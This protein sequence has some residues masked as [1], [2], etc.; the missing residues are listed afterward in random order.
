MD[1]DSAPNVKNKLPLTFVVGKYFF[2]NLSFEFIFSLTFFDYPLASKK[3]TCKTKNTN[4]D[5]VFFLITGKIY[6]Y[7]GVCKGQYFLA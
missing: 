7:K 2:S 6:N 3:K 1:S 4:T 5:K